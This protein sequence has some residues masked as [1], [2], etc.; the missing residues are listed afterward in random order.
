[1]TV[2]AEL[3]HL[4]RRLAASIQPARP[5]DD[6]LSWARAH[7]REAEWALW[8]RHRPNDK[9]H[10]LAVAHVLTVADDVPAWVLSAAL[11]HDIGKIDADLGLPGRVLAS[12]LQ[13]ARVRRA[14]GRLGAY[15]HY[16]AH[17]ATLLRSA[18]SH[19]HVVA[20]AAEHHEPE[21]GWTVPARWGTPLAAADHR[22]V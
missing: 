18:G 22:A 19:P 21:A 14:P 5:S 12:L 16:A 20:W 9:R 4:A 11:L 17:G 13:L 2:G 8:S 1:M 6:D 3:V 10:T 7:L 15:L